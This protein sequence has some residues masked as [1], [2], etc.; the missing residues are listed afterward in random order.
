MVENFPSLKLNPDQAFKVLK[1]CITHYSTAQKVKQLDLLEYL[2]EENTEL[3][4]DEIAQLKPEL[5]GVKK[6]NPYVESAGDIEHATSTRPGQI[7]HAR[8]VEIN[9]LLRQDYENYQEANETIKSS[10]E[11]LRAEIKSAFGQ[12][13]AAALFGQDNQF[14][15][16]MPQ[17]RRLV[18]DYIALAEQRGDN[19]DIAGALE[20]ANEAFVQVL[21]VDVQYYDKLFTELDAKRIGQRELQEIFLG[22]DGVYAFVGRRAQIHARRIR[23]KLSG[24]DQTPPEP[25]TYLVYPRGFTSGLND[26]AKVAYLRQHITNPSRSLFYDTGFAGSIP[27]DILS[28]L[29]VSSE[30]WDKQIRMLS[31]NKHS[32]T[33]LGLEGS[34]SERDTIVNT[35]EH[36]A[37]DEQTA[38]G[39][40][41]TTSPNGEERLLHYAEPTEPKE[42][43]AF[44]FCQM[45]LSRHYYLRELTSYCP[46]KYLFS[47]HKLAGTS[48]I[49]ISPTIPNET[50]SEL[51]KLFNTED[52][53]EMLQQE[54]TAIKI[55]GENDPYPGE[56]VFE[57]EVAKTPIIVKSVVQEKQQGPIDEFEALILLERLGIDAPKAI[58][59]IFTQEQNGLIVMEKLGGISGRRIKDYFQE[60][61]ITPENQQAILRDALTR[62]QELVETIKRDIGF[63]KPWRLKDFMIEFTEEN[64]QI[65]IKSLKPLDFERVKIFDPDNPHEVKLGQGLDELL[66]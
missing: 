14:G 66:N 64:G 51:I 34:K 40:Y 55:A 28:V 47:A 46:E 25:P 9:K 13:Y 65:V 58:A 18:A 44:R 53:G 26:E 4:L 32:R 31:A 35:I 62:I 48:E 20:N 49:R 37:K 50:K 59:R 8:A 63:D 36:N 2:S 54:A 5:K 61:N 17:Y 23:L 30:E 56:A 42:R 38:S 21:Q 33:I 29:G 41:L 52:L 43:L 1:A 39:L 57:M 16:L 24:Y 6:K 15:N 60:Q 3:L 12:D 27:E 11:A 10:Y 45:A 19:I 22:R 7:V